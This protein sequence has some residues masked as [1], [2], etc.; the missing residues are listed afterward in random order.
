[1]P[2]TEPAL[3]PGPSEAT[4]PEEPAEAVGPLLRG[5]AVIQALTDAGGTQ[6]LSELARTVGLARSSLDRV[7]VSLEA[8]GYIHLRGRDAALAPRLMDLGNAFLSASR[9]PELLGPL[10]QEL[11]AHIDEVV[12]LTIAGPNGDYLAHKTDRPRRLALACR[13]GDRLPLDRCAGG[14]LIAA[15]WDDSAWARYREG[16]DCTCGDR[17]A[18]ACA[19]RLRHRAEAA[20]RDG[21]VLDD[22]WLEPGLIAVGIPVNGPDGSAACTANVLSFT[23]RHRTARDLADA[24]LPALERAAA[25]MESALRDAPAASASTAAP[26]RSDAV[27]A[28]AARPGVLEALVRGMTVMTAFTRGQAELT[29]ADAARATGLARAT[30]RRALITLEHLGH[31]TQHDGRYRLTTS[32]LTLGFPVLARMSLARIAQPHLEELSARARHSASLAVLENETEIMYVARAATPTR[33]TTVQLHVGTRLPAY[34]TSLGRVLLAARPDE[35]SG[36]AIRAARPTPLTTRT[37][38]DTDELIRILRDVRTAGYAIV[39]EELEVGLRSIA[40]PIR[41]HDGTTL[42]A[43]N[44]AMHIDNRTGRNAATD[45]LPDLLAAADAI[46]RDLLAFGPFGELTTV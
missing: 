24:A 21:Y 29:I 39:D 40:V 15:T 23:S 36:Q 12:T 44:I 28:I 43:V 22:E 26:D 14:A 1:M 32:V 7:L 38:T 10:A 20:A 30:V 37:V 42:A 35:R 4:R 18:R 27:A 6:S 8:L 13:V 34:A 11:S 19:E 16:R 17:D 46:H 2:T 5:I 33:L 25:A 41:S 3:D 45:H 9:I 31:I